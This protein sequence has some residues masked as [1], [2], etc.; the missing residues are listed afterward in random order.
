MSKYVEV[1]DV[2]NVTRGVVLQCLVELGCAH[3]TLLV[4]VCPLSVAI[5][6][7]V[8]AVIISVAVVEVGRA[9][10]VC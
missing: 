10:V 2:E 5:L 1:E 6:Y 7:S 9:D 8:L 3:A 4:T